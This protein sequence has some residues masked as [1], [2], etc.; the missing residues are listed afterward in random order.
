M[1]IQ[2][3]LNKLDE[4]IEIFNNNHIEVQNSKDSFAINKDIIQTKLKQLNFQDVTEEECKEVLGRKWKVCCKRIVDL[5]EFLSKSKYMYCESAWAVSMI[6]TT[7]YKVIKNERKQVFGSAQAIEHTIQDMEKL[8]ILRCVDQHYAQNIHKARSYLLSI[9]RIRS[10]VNIITYGYMDIN[11]DID[12]D[13]KIYDDDNNE[14]EILDIIDNKNLEMLVNSLNLRGEIALANK[15][16]AQV[17]RYRLTGY[18]PSANICYVASREKAAL[19]KVK[20]EV[21]REDIVKKDFGDLQEFDRNASI[22]N[23]MLFL[24]KGEIRSNDRKQFDLYEYLNRG[25][26]SL[27]SEYHNIWIYG[28]LKDKVIN[29]NNNKIKYICNEKEEE[30]ELCKCSISNSSHTPGRADVKNLMMT[31]YFAD[32]RQIRNLVEDTVNYMMTR[33]NR[34]FKKAR[35]FASRFESVIK[36]LGVSDIEL[37]SQEDYLN[38]SNAVLEWFKDAK[39]LLEDFLGYNLRDTSVFLY[40]AYVNLHCC[41]KLKELGYT[42][43]SVY[44][45][46]YTDCNEETWWKC[47]TE[48]LNCLKQLITK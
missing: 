44:D 29:S 46:F 40:E 41:N 5:Y 34:C 42:C 26:M 32:M 37:E 35:K 38:L 47:Y 48:S 21:Y 16:V 45:G 36:Y 27:R 43:V 39:K 22:Y 6:S 15:G 31:L 3:S 13:I 9:L 8:D 1:T 18:R 2:E 14:E 25:L 7:L 12:K 28:I 20:H 11:K 4:A 30:E 33:D 10:I 17:Y 23:L 19:H 24:G